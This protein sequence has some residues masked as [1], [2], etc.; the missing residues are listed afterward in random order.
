[1]DLAVLLEL[2]DDARLVGL[3][4][5]GGVEVE[6]GLAVGGLEGADDGFGHSCV[7]FG[8]FAPRWNSSAVTTVLPARCSRVRRTAPSGQAPGSWSSPASPGSPLPAS[9]RAWSTLILCPSS[10]NHAPG[11]GERPR[12]CA[13]TS[14]AGLSQPILLSA[15]NT[16]GAMVTPSSVCGVS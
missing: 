9:A 12:I 3:A 16:F 11:K 5:G 2:L 15:G 6:H 4:E 13:E 14:C 7:P 10:S 8:I 1:P